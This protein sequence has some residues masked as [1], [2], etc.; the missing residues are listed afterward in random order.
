MGD[1]EEVFR[2]VTRRQDR[3]GFQGCQRRPNVPESACLYTIMENNHKGHYVPVWVLF[4]NVSEAVRV[5]GEVESINQNLYNDAK[6]LLQ[7]S[8]DIYYKNLGQKLEAKPYR[9]LSMDYSEN[10]DGLWYVPYEAELIPFEQFMD[11]LIH[12][13]AQFTGTDNSDTLDPTEDD[14]SRDTS[15]PKEHQY[16]TGSSEDIQRWYRLNK[17]AGPIGWKNGPLY[18]ILIELMNHL[19]QKTWWHIDQFVSDEE[20][21]VTAFSRVDPS[22]PGTRIYKLGTIFYVST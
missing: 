22:K 1:Y 4:D 12:V 18:T 10:I 7:Q 17:H 19:S 8:E 15:L 6:A 2:V 20:V 21:N 5:A 16:G 3:P 11:D 13:Y 14:W 9:P